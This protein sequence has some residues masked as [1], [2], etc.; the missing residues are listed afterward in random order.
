MPLKISRRPDGQTYISGQTKEFAQYEKDIMSGKIPCPFTAVFRNQD[1]EI[2]CDG[3]MPLRL[4][5]VPKIKTTFTNPYEIGT[6]KW[7]EI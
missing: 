3:L 2:V 4:N 6:D 1:G 5:G 7:Y